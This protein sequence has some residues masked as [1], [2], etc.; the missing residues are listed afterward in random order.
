M[1]ASNCGADPQFEIATARQFLRDWQK[2]AP[3]ALR[4]SVDRMG[5]MA[6]VRLLEVPTPPGRIE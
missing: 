4:F 2:Q 1:A 3:M 5:N 6:H